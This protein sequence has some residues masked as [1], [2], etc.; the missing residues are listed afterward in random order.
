MESPTNVGGWDT[1]DMLAKAG[2]NQESEVRD[3]DYA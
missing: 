2:I 1:I 3:C